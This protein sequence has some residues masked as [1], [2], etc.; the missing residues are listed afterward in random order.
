MVN[1]KLAQIKILCDLMKDTECVI[2]WNDEIANIDFV[3]NNNRFKLR[4]FGNVARQDLEDYLEESKYM[5][6][7]YESTAKKLEL[8]LLLDVLKDEEK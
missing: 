3:G 8:L 4:V 2:D 5:I 1:E 7:F 6:K